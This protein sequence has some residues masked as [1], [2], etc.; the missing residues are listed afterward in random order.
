MGCASARAAV[1]A[2]AEGFYWT[3]NEQ[4]A[5]RAV[6]LIETFFL[7]EATAM[8]PNFRY[9]QS[10]G[11]PCEPPACSGAVLEAKV[12]RTTRPAKALLYGRWGSQHASTA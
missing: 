2:L 6:L 4:W 7:N 12:E 3:R 1:S 10:L 8:N 9:G 5:Q 11:Y